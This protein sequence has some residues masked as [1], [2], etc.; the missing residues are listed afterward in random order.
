L[1]FPK[2]LDIPT[3]ILQIARTLEDAGFEAWCVGGTLRDRLLGHPGSDYDIATS[4]TPQQ[5]QRLFRRTIAVGVKYGTVGVLDAQRQLHEVTTFRRDVTTDGRH[6]VVQ[7]GVALDDDLARRDFTINALAYHPFRHEWRDPFGG[8]RD[9]EAGVVRAVGNP[10]ERFREDYL[11]I[12]RALRFAARFDFTIEPD[13]WNAAR[14]AADGLANLSAERVREEW[15]KGL[16]TAKSVGRLASLWVEI[17]AARVWLPELELEDPA[18]AV[19]QISAEA[20]DPVL[21]TAVMVSSPTTVLRRLKA[22]NAQVERAE[23]IERGPP[24][25][26]QLDQPSIRRWLSKVGDSADDLAQLWQLRRG[27]PAPWAPAVEEIR[28]RGDPLTRADLAI[29]GSDL[30][31][32]GTSGPRIGQILAALL[33]RVLDEP[34]LNTRE[35]LLALA[36]KM[37]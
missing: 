13:T 9:L 31:T 28:R 7:Y 10:A 17:G 8:G 32:L 27:E 30:Q 14:A 5:V 19:S 23:A 33:D 6:A 3:P 15:F 25:P 21:L 34:A 4:A 37:P 11:R 24:S 12:L 20:R 18:G 29:T 16:Q 36:R 26:A 22:S 1:R 2:L 35:T